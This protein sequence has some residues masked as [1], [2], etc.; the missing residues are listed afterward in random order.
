MALMRLIGHDADLRTKPGESQHAEVF[1]SLLLTQLESRK[2]APVS[3]RPYEPVRAV[4]PVSPPELVIRA[5]PP[6]GGV[7]DFLS[8]GPSADTSCHTGFTA[9]E[10]DE[11][12]PRL[13]GAD[14]GAY[15]PRY[16]FSG[17]APVSTPEVARPARLDRSQ[18][19]LPGEVYPHRR[20]RDGDRV[21]S[22]CQYYIYDYVS[23][24]R[25][26]GFRDAD[27]FAYITMDRKEALG[28]I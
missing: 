21:V 18:T 3:S 20:Y 9:R 22:A 27:R 6:S 19:N 13:V 24:P 4:D 11:K 23:M 16:D 2:G 26:V 5:I 17:A 7:S 10:V 1:C 14:R 25:P 28:C 12:L 8:G 15:D